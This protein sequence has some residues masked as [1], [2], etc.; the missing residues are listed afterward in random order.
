MECT[1]RSS[2]TVRIAATERLREHL[3]AEDAA[4]RHPLARSGEDVLAGARPGVGEVEGGEEAG[5]GV[6]HA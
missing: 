5:Q 4:E 6:I 1:V 3:P 2:G